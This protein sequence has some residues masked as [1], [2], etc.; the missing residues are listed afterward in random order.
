MSGV[1]DVDLSVGV[2]VFDNSVLGVGRV[3]QTCGPSRG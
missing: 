3:L 1:E 2:G